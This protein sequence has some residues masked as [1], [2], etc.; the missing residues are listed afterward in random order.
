MPHNE[1]TRLWILVT[2]GRRAR[3]MV[4][5]VQEGHFRTM[6]PLGVAEHPHY[7][8]ALRHG[9]VH[10][11]VN[12]FTADVARRLNEAAA[13]NEFEELVL[14]APG[15][16]GRDIRDVLGAEALARLVGT[17]NRDYMALDDATLSVHLARWWLPPTG[18]PDFGGAFAPSA[19][20]V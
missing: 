14:V 7:P 19:Q 12:Q 5:D 15:T 18:A 10:D 13:Q 1:G 2:D 17:L 11:S 6:L 3:I 4:P 9:I 20:M 8:P 16:V